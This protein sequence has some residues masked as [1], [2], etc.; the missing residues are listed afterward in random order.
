MCDML[1]VCHRG[2]VADKS[3]RSCMYSQPVENKEWKC[4][5]NGQIIPTDF[6]PIGCDAWSQF[7]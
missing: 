4:H 2:E 1:P 6:I 5:Q 7:K 3:C